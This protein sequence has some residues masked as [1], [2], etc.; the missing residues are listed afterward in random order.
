MH[1]FQFY[2]SPDNF[3]YQN[4]WRHFL[5][6]EFSLASLGGSRAL[7]P[8]SLLGVTLPT[9]KMAGMRWLPLESNPDVSKKPKS[10][11]IFHDNLS[12]IPFC[13]SLEALDVK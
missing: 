8:E 3:L 2:D 12:A 4:L 9:S 13:N 11:D 6:Q 7:D 10:N 1:A 5:L